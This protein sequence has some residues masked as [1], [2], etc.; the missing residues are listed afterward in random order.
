M[1]LRAACH[2][3]VSHQCF[4]SYVFSLRTGVEGGLPAFFSKIRKRGLMERC[5]ETLL[6]TLSFNLLI[7]S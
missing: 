5:D 2:I 6:P 7:L 3:L 1:L 4:G